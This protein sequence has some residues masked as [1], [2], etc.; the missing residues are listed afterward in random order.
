MN[1]FLIH[2]GSA[3]EISLS[4]NPNSGIIVGIYQ[5]IV[6]ATTGVFLYRWIFK[7]GIRELGV[8]TRNGNISMNFFYYFVLIWSLVVF[9][10][11]S[12][13]YFFFPH[14]WVTMTSIELPPLNTMVATLLFQSFFPGF[15][16]EIFFRGLIVNLLMTLVFTNYRDNKAGRI[17]VILLSSI[18]FATAHIYFTIA[19]FRITHIDYLQLGMAMGCGVFYAI[20][21]LKT[22]S[23]VAPFLAH[24][25]SNT[26]S[27]ICGYL[28]ASL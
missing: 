18:Y 11:C 23:L 26:T 7:K 5:Q 10:Y 13:L 16:E 1:Q 8:N 27:T 17:G 21:F 4:S 20:A 2:S 14:T 25:F 24:N 6:Q 12:V 9:L 3:L 28:I 22:R 19:P 15:G